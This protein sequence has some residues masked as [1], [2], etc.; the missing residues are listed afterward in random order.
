MA[1][2][3]Y[4]F[5][6]SGG[7]E[8]QHSRDVVGVAGVDQQQQ[9]VRP[10]LHNHW[11]TRARPGSGDE[12]GP[13]DWL[14]R[15]LMTSPLVFFLCS[16][17]PSSARPQAATGGGATSSSGGSAGA[18]GVVGGPQAGPTSSVDVWS[19]AHVGVDPLSP[20]HNHQQVHQQQVGPRR[21]L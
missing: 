5:S 12:G 3:H 13:G 19:T 6:L 21:P 18:N 10:H 20:Y 14:P 7:Y 8:A 2:A 9:Q 16:F 4:G 17:F 11:K 15:R 1:Q